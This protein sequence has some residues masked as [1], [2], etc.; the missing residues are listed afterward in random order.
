MVFGCLSFDSE[1]RRQ[2]SR[3]RIA[4]FVAITAR[5]R[6]YVRRHTLGQYVYPLTSHVRVAVARE[7]EMPESRVDAHD[8]GAMLKGFS[9]DVSREGPRASA[10]PS[11]LDN[12]GDDGIVVEG[13]SNV[14]DTARKFSPTG[15]TLRSDHPS[16]AMAS[17]AIEWST[18]APDRTGIAHSC[19]SL[20]IVKHGASATLER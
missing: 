14:G 10:A 4:G 17:T 9:T 3:E 6:A 5:G 11:I 13:L 20:Q 8:D 2:E 15:V 1:R 7:L 16:G 12:D 19:D 18:W